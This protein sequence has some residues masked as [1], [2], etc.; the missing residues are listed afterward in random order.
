[1][2]LAILAMLAAPAGSAP[3]ALPGFTPEQTRYIL[4]EAERLKR[5]S[6]LSNEQALIVYD[7]CLSREAASLSRTDLGEG[8]IFDRA[9]RRCIVLRAELLSGSPPERFIQFKRLD[10]AKA[11]AFP[12][13]TRH[14]RERRAAFEA[15]TE[16]A[17]RAPN[18]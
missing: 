2:I 12:A 4:S 15:E 9:L 13:L 17:S 8:E 1:M 11:A 10:E 5:I 3:Q 14:V 6:T 7:Q 16:K 18:R